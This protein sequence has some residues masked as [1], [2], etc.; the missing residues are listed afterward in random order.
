MHDDGR[1]EPFEKDAVYVWTTEFR[2]RMI[3]VSQKQGIDQFRSREFKF[4]PMEGIVSNQFW[5]ALSYWSPGSF[6]VCGTCLLKCKG[7]NWRHL[8]GTWQG[9]T[10]RSIE[11]EPAFTNGK[12]EMV[13]LDD[14][15]TPIYEVEER[16]K[17]DSAGS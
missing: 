9:F 1:E 3:G 8:I 13:K 4:Y 16:L 10:A 14:K 11:D 15:L 5:I 17:I 7:V 12:V 2:I 6:P